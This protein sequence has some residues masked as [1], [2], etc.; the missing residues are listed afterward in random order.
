MED[1]VE[2]VGE[3]LKYLSFHRLRIDPDSNYN[4]NDIDPDL[5]KYMPLDVIKIQP[6]EDIKKIW[7]FLTTKKK[8]ELEQ[9]LPCYKHYNTPEMEEHIDGPPPSKIHCYECNKKKRSRSQAKKKRTHLPNLN[10]Y[11]FQKKKKLSHSQI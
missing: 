11:K 3:A 8:E 4:L 6:A 10:C 1:I 9:Y 7:S 5:I 2:K